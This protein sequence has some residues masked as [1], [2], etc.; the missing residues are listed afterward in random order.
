[1]KL[2]GTGLITDGQLGNRMFQVMFCSELQRHCPGFFL[3]RVHLPE[4]GLVLKERE[5]QGKTLHVGGGFKHDF[6]YL[7]YLLNTGVYDNIL[8]D[9]LC[10]RME[11]YPNRN[12]YQTILHSNAT[13][14]HEYLDDQ[15]LLIHI[16]AGDVLLGY[17]SDYGPVPVNFFAQI[18][19]ETNL[20][21]VFIGQLSDDFYS[22]AIRA[23][24]PQAIYLEGG[25][26]IQ[27]FQTIRSAT[28]IVA[29]VS[30]YAFLA[31]WL[32]Y[33]AKNIFLPVKGLLN[34]R[35]CSE[36]NLLPLNDSRYRFYKFDVD[37]W[38]A[39]DEQKHYLVASTARIGQYQRDELLNLISY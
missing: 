15:H 30:T 5:T 36:I 22:N 29:S 14:R 39:T 21:P 32:A 12:E 1:M 31:S 10:L 25:S 23:R 11:Y 34:P 7:S 38:K 16:R 18:V 2:I 37:E 19:E 13:S 20:K 9:T 4:F 17:N 35:Q 8:I 26:A 6:T 24:F 27:D 28:N 33:D 3:H